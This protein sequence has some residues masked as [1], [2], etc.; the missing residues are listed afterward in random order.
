MDLTPLFH[1]SKSENTERIRVQKEHSILN[2]EILRNFFRIG[3]E[4][5]PTV[6]KGQLYN[7]KSKMIFQSLE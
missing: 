7:S 1:M 5:Y 4:M 3:E 6:Y 2:H